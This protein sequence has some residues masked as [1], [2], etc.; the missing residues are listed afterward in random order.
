M[1]RFRKMAFGAV[2]PGAL[3]LA[4]FTTSAA[5]AADTRPTLTKVVNTA[6][7]AVPVA[8]QGTTRVAGEVAVTNTP[9]VRLLAGSS[10]ALDPSA[11]T[12]RVGESVPAQP[13]AAR[14]F[15]RAGAGSASHI[16]NQQLLVVPPGKTG[17]IEMAS[18][19]FTTHPGVVPTVW[20]F[21]G[22]P[23]VPSVDDARHYLAL[24]PQ[25]VAENPSHKR[26][27]FVGAGTLRLYA[28]PGSVVRALLFI[29]V[30]RD[31]SDP[32]SEVQGE[33]A[34]TGY[35]VDAP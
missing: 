16:S 5:W 24:T 21:I 6:A 7:E 27:I 9:S 2:A 1:N 31:Q 30:A 32:T 13:L 4:L 33:V 17:V 22:D 25:G 14:A 35:F 19:F 23:N 12:V 10:V 8:P 34:V 15:L 28:P 3:V 11:N 20:V 29:P 26:S 18:A